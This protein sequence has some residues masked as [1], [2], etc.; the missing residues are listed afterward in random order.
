MLSIIVAEVSRVISAGCA[1]KRNPADKMVMFYRHELDIAT[2]L[3]T[4]K[5][6]PSAL[7]RDTFHTA[8]AVYHTHASLWSPRPTIC[9]EYAQHLGKY[10]NRSNR[11]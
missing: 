8:G 9:L 11:I 5:C 4:A 2:H 1:R 6:T 10:T 3:D 7:E